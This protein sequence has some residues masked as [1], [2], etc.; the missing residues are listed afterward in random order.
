ML[1][2]G[3]E[4]YDSFIFTSVPEIAVLGLNLGNANLI[5]RINKTK[6]VYPFLETR[7]K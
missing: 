7:V 3:I 5:F 4:R 6:K 1:K 2:I